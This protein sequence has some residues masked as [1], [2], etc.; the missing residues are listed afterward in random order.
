M[1]TRDRR[2][3]S[4]LRAELSELIRKLKDPRIGFVSITDVEVTGDGKYAR[5][6]VSIFGDDTAKDDTLAAL[7]R[8]A[9]HLRSELG[10]VMHLRITPELQFRL[11]ESIERGARIER[12]LREIKEGQPE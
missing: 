5:V 2:L 3:R 1:T 4:A 7:R 6:F 11:D 10:R 9:G 12:V 8:A